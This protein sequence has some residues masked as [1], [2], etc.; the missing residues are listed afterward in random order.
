[1]STLQ[2]KLTN[3]KN[4]KKE[5]KNIQIFWA[6]FFIYTLSFVQSSALMNPNFKLYNA[7]QAL[8]LVILVY[9]TIR[10]SHFKFETNYLKT[11]FILYFFWIL[12]VILRGV[13]FDYTFFKKI[14]FDPYRGL[15]LYLAPLILLF[16]LKIFNLRT[17]FTIT[18]VF[19]VCFILY[20]LL[21][22]SRL[23]DVGTED[24]RTLLEYLAKTLGLSAGLILLTYSYHTFRKS[25]FSVILILITLFFA[26]LQARRGLIF[27]SSLILL[28]GIYTLLYNNKKRV[29][30]VLVTVTFSVLAFIGLATFIMQDNKFF[31]FVK[32]R[33]NED[34][35]GELE[36][37]YYADMDIEDWTIGRG[38]S[39]LIAAPLDV[40]DENSDSIPGYRDG[41][42]ADY[43]NII[44]KGG[45]ISLALLLLMTVPAIFQGLF[46]SKNTL[47]KASGM[48]ILLWILDLYPTTVTTF[49]LNYLL[50][51]IC[52]GICYSSE[53]RNMDDSSLK[54]LFNK[55]LKKL[56]Q[57][58]KIEL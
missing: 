11:I 32:E 21:F 48:W 52:V 15:F 4:V 2:A 10:L 23:F 28:F 26:I 12:I 42:E 57:D 58:P 47:S 51:W 29:S 45:I 50:V 33:K 3:K 43:L 16:P 44:L 17:A 38:M 14:I 35:R 31:K 49:T 5:A 40:D 41:I 56:I 39:G 37:F 36:I 7:V 19:G 46:N 53:I 20:V 8:G 1:M 27:T 54:E 25:A 34:T 24:A 55:P 30:T 6:G 13:S 22:R 9:A 18:I